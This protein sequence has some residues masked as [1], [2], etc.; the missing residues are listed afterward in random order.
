MVRSPLKKCTP[1]RAFIGLEAINFQGKIFKYKL[2]TVLTKKGKSPRLCPV[3]QRAPLKTGM[4]LSVTGKYRVLFTRRLPAVSLSA[5]WGLSKEEN[6]PERAGKWRAC[7]AASA[8]SRLTTLAAHHER[9]FH[10]ASDF[11]ARSRVFFFARLSLRG[12]RDYSSSN[13]RHFAPRHG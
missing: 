1:C 13:L 2:G 9:G 6:R 7:V 3:K 11:H 12:T 5:W 4:F 10:A 8:M